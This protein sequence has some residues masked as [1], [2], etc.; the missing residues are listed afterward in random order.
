MCRGYEGGCFLVT[1]LHEVTAVATLAQG[2]SSPVYAVARVAVD[3]GGLLFL[4]FSYVLCFTLLDSRRYQREH[5]CVMRCNKRLAVR[6]EMNAWG[7]VRMCWLYSS[8]YKVRSYP[9]RVNWLS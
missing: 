2:R 9:S 1:H 7:P 3:P 6:T 4:T 8:S 5:R